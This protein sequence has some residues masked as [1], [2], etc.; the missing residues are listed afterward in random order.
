MIWS[1]TTASCST[2]C[3]IGRSILVSRT[4]FT[5]PAR[6]LNAL[7][8]AGAPAIRSGSVAPVRASCEAF[9]HGRIAARPPIAASAGDGRMSLRGNRVT[10]RDSFLFTPLFRPLTGLPRVCMSVAGHG[11]LSPVGHVARLAVNLSATASQGSIRQVMRPATTFRLSLSD[12][13]SIPSRSRPRIQRRH[14]PFRVFGRLCVLEGT[15][16]RAGLPCGKPSV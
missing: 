16:L 6:P 8:V 14:L 15:M 10:I 13:A 3:E 9:E 5:V 4:T 2:L 11:L 12:I 7:H 1:C